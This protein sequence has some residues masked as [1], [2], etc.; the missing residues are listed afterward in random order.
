MRSAASKQHEYGAYNLSEAARELRVGRTTL[1][2][3]IDDKEIDTF[4]VRGMR[5]VAAS[6]IKRIRGE[7]DGAASNSNLP[8]PLPGPGFPQL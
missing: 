3:M 5:R 7:E 1:Y 6:E 8:G 2:R 4:I